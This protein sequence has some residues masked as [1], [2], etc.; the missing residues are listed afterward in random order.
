MPEERIGAKIQQ[1]MGDFQ[2]RLQRAAMACQDEVKDRN[3][4]DPDKMTTAFN[5]CM[6]GV[7]D[8]HAKM[9]PGIKKRVMD[10]M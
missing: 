1:E 6:T 5:K 9:L 8:K 10:S 3:L 4:T 7:F 2:S